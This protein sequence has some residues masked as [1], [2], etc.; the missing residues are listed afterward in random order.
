MQVSLALTVLNE[1]A[2]ARRLF[3]SIVE[4]TRPPDEVIV[5]DG[6]CRDDTLAVIAEYS[7]RL[8]L[9]T[10]RQPGANISTGRNA[11]IR[12][13]CGDII[14]VTDAGV[15]LAPD[16]LK[17]LTGAFER[18]EIALA[19]GFFRADA[20][21]MFETAMGATVLPT[22]QDIDPAR[23][24]PSSRSV[25]FRKSAW[26]SIGGYPEWLDYSED[27]VFD[28]KMRE[29]FGAFAFV[30][31]ALVHFRPRGSLAA[32]ARQYFHYAAG[33][34]HADLFATLHFTRYFTYLLALPLGI[35]AAL[36]VHPAIWALG[37]LAGLAYIRRPL[38]RATGLWGALSPAKRVT[39]LLLLPVIRVVGDLAKMAGY[40]AGL[41]KRV[42]RGEK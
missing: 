38:L 9:H 26:E 11:A 5:C 15:R 27:V 35:Y 31:G 33:D 37:A 42:A 16:W 30:P 21:T 40:P 17:Q 8:P 24:L 1:G 23:F 18:D 20:Q 29:R 7:D 13:A 10:L 12:A 6:G 39:V 14:A 4:Q 41:W 2:H 32:F 19:A 28:L 22:L 3:D 25:A 36:S 34:G